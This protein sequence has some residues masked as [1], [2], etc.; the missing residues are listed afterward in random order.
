MMPLSL[1]ILLQA[2][3]GATEDTS[4][5]QIRGRISIP[6]KYQ[7][8]LP[9][10]GG[11]AAVKVILDGGLRSTLP[12][13]DGTF[14]I[15]GVAAG[16][17]LLQVVHPTLSFD[18]VRVEASEASGA[19]KM[20]A[21]MADL[22]QGRGAKLKYPLGLAPSGTFQYLE[23]REDFN[24]LSVFKSPMALISLFSMGAML[25]LPKLQPMMEEEKARQRLEAE[26]EGAA[27][28]G[29]AKGRN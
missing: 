23:K 18:S 22:E 13:A 8:D 6:N 1:A 3:W 19:F 4:L 5:G 29:D 11:L 25:L 26:G 28:V 10:G 14:A 20:S 16:P 9:A 27:A 15:N 24:I 12:I 21:H 17:H 7:Q 2:T